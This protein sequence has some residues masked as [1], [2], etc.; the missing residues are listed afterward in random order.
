MA[1][2]ASGAFRQTVADYLGNPNSFW[3]PALPHLDLESHRGALFTNAVTPDYDA[4]AA[5]AK[6]G[7]GGTWTTANEV[8]GTGYTAGGALLTSTTVTTPSTGIVMFD[9]ADLAWSSATF[10]NAYGLLVY[11]D[12]LTAPVADQAW[13][14]LYFGGTAYSVTAGTFTVQFSASGLWRFAV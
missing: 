6:Y 4:A 14:A 8:S 11:A 9:A 7:T 12:S 2:S 3:T 10:S 5:A 1:W 13:L